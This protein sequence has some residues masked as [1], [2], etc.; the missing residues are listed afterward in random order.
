MR[1]KDIKS[2][3]N[4]TTMTNLL[5]ET[6]EAITKSG[7]NTSDIDWIGSKSGRKAFTS[8]SAFADAADKEYDADFGT[9]EVSPRLVIVFQDASWLE[10]IEYDGSEAWDYKCMPEIQEEW[11]SLT[12]VFIGVDAP[13]K[14]PLKDD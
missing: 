6:R 7:H 8:Y 10:R 11:E 13:Y 2:K 14:D 1:W 5:E 9:L 12:D 4:K 3:Y